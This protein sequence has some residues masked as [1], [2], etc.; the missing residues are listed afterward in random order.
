M[1]GFIS[2]GK[3]NKYSIIKHKSASAFLAK[4]DSLY[5]IQYDSLYFNDDSGIIFIKNITIVPDT[6][7]MKKGKALTS[8][9]AVEIKVRSITIKGVKS[10]QVINNH[11]LIGDSVII[12][13][14]Q[15]T[16]L[17][18]K[19]VNRETKINFEAREI[20][21]QILSRLKLIR[22][23]EVVIKNAQIIAV[24]F[25]NYHRQFELYNTNIHLHDV[26]IDSMR[27]ED[28]SRVLFCKDASFSMS[29]FLSFNNNR[30]EIKV[31]NIS[32]RGTDH[33]FIFSKALL[34]RFDNQT[35][36][37]LPLIEGFNLV[38][39]GIDNKEVVNNKNILIDSIFCD[40]ILF[41]RSPK[42]SFNSHQVIHSEFSQKDSSGFRAAYSLHL[43]TIFFPWID[44]LENKKAAPPMYK[45]GKLSLIVKEVEADAILQMQVHPVDHIQEFIINCHDLNYASQDKLYRQRLENLNINSLHKQITI[46]SFKLIPL[47][48]EKSFAKKLRVQKDRYNIAMDGISIN[49]LN[50]PALL[51]TKII[52]GDIK[53]ASSH[54][55]IYRDI[56]GPLDS[57]S[58]I[59]NYPQQILEKTR[60]PISIK[61]VLLNNTSI[62]YKEQNATKHVS[63]TVRFDNTRITMS[64]VTNLRSASG[65]ALMKLD[66]RVLGQ[67]PL[68]LSFKF[69]L[70]ARDGK[71][72]VA[73]SI[74]ECD[75]RSLNEISRSLALIQID[76]GFI[77]NA[78]F[79]FIGDDNATQG[80]FTMKY[81]HLKIALLKNAD[82]NILKKRGIMSFFANSIIRNQ[83]PKNGRLRTYDVQYDREKYKSFFSLVWKTIFT[84]MKAT[85][86]LPMPKIK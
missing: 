81:D 54:I 66:T 12:D 57:I 67:V 50:L 2:Y 61:Y 18:L 59:G 76:S 37:G 19:K 56:S 39:A 46:G 48:T 52:A 63:G 5:S 38:M 13:E 80:H 4:S 17:L 11:E 55:D 79:D 28:T 20:Y 22:V 9:A 24:N 29:Q 84:G 26:L 58:K 77:H 41:Y 70:H 82:E 69:P 51:E 25:S 40:H 73:G 42:F 7:R 75:M 64:N 30:V 45:L 14:P 86:G 34:N 16:A 44:I 71:F 65:D 62:K 15:I 27:R 68:S 6:V 60:F 74:G 33:K 83:N 3:K 1:L 23:K 8:Y 21:H 85:V 43:K 35:G 31:D 72:A 47:L 49:D 36:T 32:F 78:T 10:R 53:V